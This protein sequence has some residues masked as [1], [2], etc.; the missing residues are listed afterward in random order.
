MIR[1]KKALAAILSAAMVM[2]SVCVP[3]MA[4]ESA[5]FEVETEEVA[6]EET[7]D[8]NEEVSEEVVGVEAETVSEEALDS[9]AV[10]EDSAD[11]AETDAAV[12]VTI[13]K[14]EGYEEGAYATWSKIAD[15]KGYRAYVKAKADSEWIKLDNELVRTY[16]DYVRADAVGLAAGTYNLKIVTV[17]SD[18]TTAETVTADLTVTNYDRSGFAFSSDSMLEA[19][20]DK[21]PTKINT[22]KDGLGAYKADGTLK[23]GAQ[24]IYVTNETANKVQA[25][26]AIN[27]KGG[28]DT[29]TG[30]QNIIYGLQK[31]YH[32]KPVDIR[33][34]G[35]I[36]DSSMDGFGSSAEGLQ[37]KGAK[38]YQNMNLTI[39]GIGEDAGIHGFGILIRNSSNCEFRNFAVMA[40]MD[41]SLSLDTA[42]SLIWIHDMDFFY[43]KT[44]GDSDQAKGDGTVDI[45]GHSSFITVAYN[46]LFDNGK[47][48]LCGMKS[49]NE[50]DYIT[51]HH[52][53][54]DHSDSRHPR[55]RS[56]SV[57]IYNNYFD[58]NAKYGVGVTMGA[59]AFVEKNYFRAVKHPMLSSKQGTDAKGD[60]TFSGENGGMI[61][62]FDNVMEES[63][64]VIYQDKSATDFDAI[65]V[66]KRDD[67]VTDYKTIAGGTGY[68]NFDTAMDLH[69]KNLEET[70]T[71]KATVTAKAGRLNG[72]DFKWTFEKADDGDYSLN[73]ALKAAVM[74]YKAPVK[75]IGGV[76]GE[77]TTPVGQA[78]TAGSDDDD[79][80]S[81]DDDDEDGPTSII[82]SEGNITHNFTEDLLSSPFFRI[83]GNTSSSKGTASYGGKSFTVC[84][85]MESAT[86]I[87]FTTK[88]SSDTLKL[89]MGGAT[90]N[91]KVDDKKISAVGGVITVEN[92]APGTHTITK[93]DTA[94]LFYI[95]LSGEPSDVA[96]TKVTLNKKALSLKVGESDTLTATVEPADATR[97]GVKWSSS[98]TAVAIVDAS[99]KVTA[100]GAGEADITATSTDNKEIKDTCKVTV[101]AADPA[102]PSDPTDPSNPTDPTDPTNPTNSEDFVFST[103]QGIDVSGNTISF[104]IA[105]AKEA[106]YNG[107]GAK[108]QVIVS[109]NGIELNPANKEVQ[110]KYKNNKLAS[111]DAK[112]NSIV[113]NPKKQPVITIKIKKAEYKKIKFAKGANEV[114][115]DIKPMDL[116][117]RVVAATPADIKKAEQVSANK[118]LKKAMVEK[119][120]VDPEKGE[121][122]IK[123]LK[124]NF[125]KDVDFA[126]MLATVDAEGKVTG[127]T[128][129]LL[130]STQVAPG[131]TYGVYLIG[132]G[133]FTGTTKNA[134]ASIQIP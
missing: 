131:N 36:Y 64:S 108:P 29:F 73:T 90:E 56:M 75:K 5:G 123:D 60:G 37:V 89:V 42:N 7:A 86:N 118:V 112:G 134:I 27:N 54:F 101:T 122:G 79:P 72:G 57:H 22:A 93:G 105:V 16:E 124:L 18:D 50:R 10:S 130:D 52:N 121:K 127:Y 28:E 110:I 74:S 62:A 69:A 31:G 58:G 80:T 53:W 76:E 128:G 51:Y 47:S 71:V 116:S 14:A 44:G 2:T 102:D 3:V 13:T 1:H 6:V 81:E 32:T 132:K 24:V 103:I 113:T 55:I 77:N 43:G 120:V 129:S 94:N 100:K 85:K 106:E 26:I 65:L 35:T 107:K 41:D 97:K 48:S 99:G 40:C 19:N 83:S 84:L 92:I 91:A 95:V 20:K 68:N 23:D 119:V 25:K 63:G 45:K 88:G 126:Y 82:D 8:T 33:I 34:V 109:I 59:S 114:S 11:E 61:K 96:V 117:K 98:N 46:H 38:A 15:A 87:T 21:N 115:F 39:E 104:N 125:K 67:K 70:S 30:L 78:A 49:E 12:A 17:M 66:S 9:E 111:L 4:E 133:N